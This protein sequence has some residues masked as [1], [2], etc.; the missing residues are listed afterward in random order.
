MQRLTRLAE[1]ETLLTG[2]R[3]TAAGIVRRI[4]KAYLRQMEDEKP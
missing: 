2:I 1:A 4:I 3:V